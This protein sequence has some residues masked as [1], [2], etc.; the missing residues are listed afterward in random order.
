MI[1]IGM[2]NYLGH[3]DQGTF[4]VFQGRVWITKSEGVVH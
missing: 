4:E 3:S 1:L 2:V